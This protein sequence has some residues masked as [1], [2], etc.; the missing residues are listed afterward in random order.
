[1]GRPRAL[2][3][4]N[5]IPRASN[6]FFTPGFSRKSVDADIDTLESALQRARIARAFFSEIGRTKCNSVEDAI[7]AD[8]TDRGHTLHFMYEQVVH[9][10]A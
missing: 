9:I 5:V 3:I 2:S 6:S 7:S 8:N 1:M 10:N 4:S